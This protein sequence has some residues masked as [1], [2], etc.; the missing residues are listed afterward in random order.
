MSYMQIGIS[1]LVSDV[2]SLLVDNAKLSTFSVEI[3][4]LEVF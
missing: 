1:R 3:T 2:E 4:S